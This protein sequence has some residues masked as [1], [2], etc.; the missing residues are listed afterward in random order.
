MRI[1]ETKVEEREMTPE[2]VHAWHTLQAR[3][4]CNVFGCTDC[5]FVHGHECFMVEH[6]IA[7]WKILKGKEVIE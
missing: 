4:T 7:A 1:R 5:P 3:K 2:E 6:A